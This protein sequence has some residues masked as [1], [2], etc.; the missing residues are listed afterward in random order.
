VGG[1]V[2]KCSGDNDCKGCGAQESHRVQS[3][4]T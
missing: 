1:V 2:E 4:E 3:L